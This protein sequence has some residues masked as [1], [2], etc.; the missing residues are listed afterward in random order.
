MILCQDASLPALRR[1]HYTV[2]TD[3]N[4]NQ[5]INVPSALNISL[6]TGITHKWH[7]SA[8]IPSLM[9]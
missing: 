5:I 8:I 2:Y 9:T 1:G 7:I 6:E 4:H 3:F